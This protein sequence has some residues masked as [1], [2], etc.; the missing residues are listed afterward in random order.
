MAAPA[1]GS[2]LPSHFQT[3]MQFLGV[4]QT[5]S[6]FKSS[7]WMIRLFYANQVPAT[8]RNMF[9]DKNH[10]IMGRSLDIV[11]FWCLWEAAK[12]CV[13]CQ[14]R[15]PLGGPTQV[16]QKSNQFCIRRF[17]HICF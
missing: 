16:N 10:E 6:P 9:G 7:D 4:L 2:F 3:V 17:I 14:L 15:T 13:V 5:G 11:K 8:L 12:F 1:L